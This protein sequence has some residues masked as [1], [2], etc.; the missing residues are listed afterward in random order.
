MHT[1]VSSLLA[2][3]I[4]TIDNTTNLGKSESLNR[5]IAIARHDIILCLY[6]AMAMLCVFALVLPFSLGYFPL[7][8]IVAAAGLFFWFT[9][10]R[11]TPAGERAW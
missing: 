11:R 5:A 8:V 3:V 7:Y 6:A 9:T 10:L 2:F 4:L 1:V